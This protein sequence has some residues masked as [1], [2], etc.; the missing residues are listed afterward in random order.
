MLQSDN[1]Y[2][3]FERAF[4]S[5]AEATDDVRA[6]FVVG[7]RARLDHP[8]DEWGDLDLIVYA[9]NCAY[10]LQNIDWLK[11]LGQIWITFTYQTASGEPERLTLFEGGYQVDI[12]FLASN[13]LY[14]LAEERRTPYNFQRGVRVLVDKDKVSG[15]I[16][17]SE[18]KPGAI[19]PIDGNA[20]AQVINMFFFTA[21]YIAKQIMRG[22]LWTAKSRENELRMLLLQMLEWH[23][24]ALHGNAYD[25]WHGGR[26]LHE[27]L[28]QTTLAE[29]KETFSK[30]EEEDS[31]RGLS[32]SINLFRRLSQ[33]TA[34]KLQ[35]AY[36]TDTDAQITNWLR[37]NMKLFL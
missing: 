30:Y 17:P 14:R 34:E 15:K 20:F 29:L 27:W 11:S 24:R 16:V 35:L 4:A 5:W 7:S 32:A 18:F 36:P 26:F 23:A 21:V 9:N 12:V 3:T 1:F 33:E 8:A 10:Y 31:L 28:D 37:E 19:P 2:R 22:E 6:V 13:C 25:V